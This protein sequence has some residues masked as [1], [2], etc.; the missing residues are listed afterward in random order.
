MPVLR[1]FRGKDAFVFLHG[2]AVGHA[3]EVIADGSVDAEF[4]D[5]FAGMLADL[6]RVLDVIREE[7]AQELLGA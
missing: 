2:V 1:S 4:A 5:A 6:G 3:G 7:V